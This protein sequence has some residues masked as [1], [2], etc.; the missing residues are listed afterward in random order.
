MDPI[1][2]WLAANWQWVLVT[3][4]VLEKVVKATPT[5]YDDI[6]FDVLVSAI[7]RLVGKPKNRAV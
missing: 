7:R 2:D 5:K 3:F 1:I 6:L 4:Y